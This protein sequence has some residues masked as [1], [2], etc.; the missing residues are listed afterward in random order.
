METFSSGKVLLL[1]Y[2]CDRINP[3]LPVDQR[4]ELLSISSIAKLAKD[5]CAGP[6]SW[7]KR[8]GADKVVMEELE[9]RPVWCLDLTF[10]H[11]LR[12]GYEFGEDR[13]A[14]LGKKIDGTEL[15]WCLGA[16]LSMIGAN[17]TCRA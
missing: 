4:D 7:E 1:S 16:T 13:Q 5:V 15:G 10:M 6:K 3:L 8:W 12:L 14:K 9:G 11:T 2:F 17:L